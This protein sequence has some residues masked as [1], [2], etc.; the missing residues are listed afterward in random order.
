MPKKKKSKLPLTGVGH[1]NS[2][3][4]SYANTTWTTASSDPGSYYV[5]EYDNGTTTTTTLPN[6]TVTIASVFG[7]T[8][9]TAR[10]TFV[11]TNHLYG[12]YEITI[13]EMPPHTHTYIDGTAVTFAASSGTY[14]YEPTML[15]ENDIISI[16][17]KG[18]VL[19]NGV[20]ELNP[21]KIGKALLQALEKHRK[22]DLNDPK[23]FFNKD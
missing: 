19:I 14:I 23:D 20:V 17:D 9:N 21:T 22:D 18:E 15:F 4:H 10:A 13:D 12:N 1:L 6:G 7:G 11:D 16:G 8:T 2:Y 5:I 3:G